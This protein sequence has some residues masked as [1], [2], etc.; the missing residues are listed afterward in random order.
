MYAQTLHDLRPKG[1]DGLHA[2]VELSADILGA[3]SFGD[4]F[5]HLKL[6]RGQGIERRFMCGSADV[7][8]EGRPGYCLGQ[9]GVAA[10]YGF[11]RN[12]GLL[13]AFAL[14]QTTL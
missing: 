11:Q 4:E 3:V 5:Q 13:A 7:L 14:C 9:P 1:F 6:A 8:G 10:R 12:D 2:E